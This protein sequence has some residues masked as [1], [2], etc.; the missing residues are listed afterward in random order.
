MKNHWKV[1]ELATL[2]GLTIRTLRY[3]DQIKLFSPSQYTESGHRLY[4]KSDLAILQQV[5]SL[6]Q[7]GLSL[8]DIHTVMKNRD[9]SS[10]TEIMETQIARVTEDIQVQQNLLYELEGVLKAVQSK[11]IIS[12]EEL[13][14]L[15]GAMKVNREKYFTKEQLDQMKG[16]YVGMDPKALKQQEKEF[17]SLLT[18]IRQHMEQ[19]TPT[20]DNEVQELANKWSDMMNRATGG[21]PEIHKAA[22]KL[23][24]ENPGNTLQNGVDA[25]IYQYLGKALE[26]K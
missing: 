4:T 17:K 5:L 14:K 1:G 23:H 12:V 13:T 25:A 3:Y 24:Y 8:D 20:S 2:T 7:I 10:A 11:G 26:G 19:G 15:L 18:K 6:K 9:K 22:E 16:H 21:D